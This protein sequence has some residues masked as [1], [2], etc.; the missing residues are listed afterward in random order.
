MAKNI[1]IKVM[2]KGAKPTVNALKNVGSA[3]TSIGVKAGIATAGFA[4]FSA[5][6]AGDFQKNLLEISFNQSSTILV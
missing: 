4:A 5:K 2:A 1:V 6:L 3:V